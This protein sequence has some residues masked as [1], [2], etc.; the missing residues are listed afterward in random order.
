MKLSNKLVARWKPLRSTTA[1]CTFFF[2]G[3][4]WF[5]LEVSNVF[6][7]Q[8]INCI[9]DLTQAQEIDA[10]YIECYRRRFVMFYKVFF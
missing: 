5:R 10:E 1:M 4:S 7:G 3:E 9:P 6:K 2:P 8:N